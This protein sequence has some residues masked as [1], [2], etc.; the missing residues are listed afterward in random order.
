MKSLFPRLFVTF[1][2]LLPHCYALAIQAE[3]D[4]VFDD[5][6]EE[7]ASAGKVDPGIIHHQN[8]DRQREQRHKDHRDREQKLAK[9]NT[10]STNSRVERLWGMPDVTATQGHV[11]KMK[12]P[13]QAF[14]GNVQRYE[15]ISTFSFSLLIL[16]I[17]P[18]RFIT[19][20]STRPGFFIRLY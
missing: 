10:S 2:L 9:E 18:T 14:G 11:F 3:D 12:I 13:K 7:A 19:R 5:V 4:L 1:L 16:F 8:Q 6:G 20:V 15:V 17:Y